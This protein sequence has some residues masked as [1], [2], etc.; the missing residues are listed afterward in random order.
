VFVFVFWLPIVS[1]DY[2]EYIYWANFWTIPDDIAEP[3]F[4]VYVD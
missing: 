3:F 4:P 1:S 2:I